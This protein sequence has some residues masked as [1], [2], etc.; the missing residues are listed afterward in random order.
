MLLLKLFPLPGCN[1]INIIVGF[2]CSAL[3]STYFSLAEQY[4]KLTDKIT[5]VLLFTS[6]LFPVITPFFIGPLIEEYPQTFL[7]LEFN[8]LVVIII[9]FITIQLIIRKFYK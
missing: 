1:H 6:Q 2:G 8:S 7:Y 4:I 9:L 3:W 5:S